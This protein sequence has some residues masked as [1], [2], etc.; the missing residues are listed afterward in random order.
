MRAS[1]SPDCRSV[2]RDEP[3]FV[4]VVPNNLS[5][6][7]FPAEFL[8]AW[9]AHGPAV[10]EHVLHLDS[11][12]RSIDN[13]C[14]TTV[15]SASALCARAI[16]H[17]HCILFL[18]FI[19]AFFLTFVGCYSMHSSLP[20]AE[21]CLVSKDSALEALARELGLSFLL[22]L[23]GSWPQNFLSEVSGSKLKNIFLNSG[24]HG[25][26]IDCIFM[27]TRKIINGPQTARDIVERKEILLGVTDERPKSSIFSSK[28]SFSEK[29]RR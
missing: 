20:F 26:V 17:R 28:K 10:Y 8:G 25:K 1:Q 7:P 5:V 23:I 6:K 13:N 12:Y 3:S 22:L 29:G 24:F 16:D 21:L 18:V 27:E 4:L 9:A 11:I 19:L 14:R 2:C 15:V